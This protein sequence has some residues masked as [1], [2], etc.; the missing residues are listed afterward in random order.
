MQAC[1]VCQQE[2]DE[3]HK[4]CPW[5][6]FKQNGDAG[7][8]WLDKVRYLWERE[9]KGKFL[10][11]NFKVMKK[12]YTP[13]KPVRKKLGDYV[14]IDA[15]PIH[16]PLILFKFPTLFKEVFVAGKLVG[17][18]VAGR[19]LEEP[20]L[21]E[22]VI[23]YQ[24]SGEWWKIFQD[25][26]IKQALKDILAATKFTE[27]SDIT[28]DKEK[29]LV[30]FKLEEAA[31]FMITCPPGRQ[32][33]VSFFL[34]G[35]CEALF[36]GFWIGETKDCQY[37]SCE[38]DVYLREDAGDFLES[39]SSK[40][41]ELV[42]KGEFEELAEK[43]VETMVHYIVEKKSSVPREKLGDFFYL[44]NLQCF[45]Y[46]LI[47]PSPGHK[48]VSKYAGIICGEKIARKAEINGAERGLKYLEELF[49]YLKTGVFSW[50]KKQD[51]IIIKIEESVYAAGVENIH[52]ELCHYFAGLIEGVLN[53]STEKRWE[54][55]ERKCIASGYSECEFHCKTL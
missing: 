55:N 40:V 23:K 45:N 34:Y 17:Y 30:N 32:C 4:F 31:C 14:H 39:M 11:K 38:V 42:E 28:V 53:K 16:I 2:V 50:D 51:R 9:E 54:V 36:D 27:I 41:T 18:Y 47:E 33:S 29:N 52:M 20:R 12:D 6:G 1:S 24:K 5:C 7:G 25:E 21:K 46:L 37:L 13:D 3:K 15:F 44:S 19:A 22:K 48:I 49:Q 43:G 35:L 26:E 8:L 10:L